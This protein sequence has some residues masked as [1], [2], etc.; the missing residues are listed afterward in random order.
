MPHSWEFCPSHSDFFHLLP[1]LRATSEGLT[2]AFR[3][4][5]KELRARDN[6]TQEELACLVGVRRETIIHIEKG[7]YNPSLQLAHDIAK[8]LRTTVDDLFIFVEE[9]TLRRS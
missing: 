9:R 7:R 8:A 5:I 1:R 4:K 2:V 6:L 3:T